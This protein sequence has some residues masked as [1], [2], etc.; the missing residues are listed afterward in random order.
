MDSTTARINYVANFD[1]Y[2]QF[3]PQSSLS[4][5]DLKAYWESGNAVK[6]ALVDG[7]VRIMKTLQYVNQVNIILPFQNNT[8]S[9]SISKEALEKFTAHDFETLIADWEKNFSDPYVYD[10]TGREKFFSKFGTIR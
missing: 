5:Q 6:K 3:N 2:K 4:E 7:S 9:I 10:R 1:E 8:Y